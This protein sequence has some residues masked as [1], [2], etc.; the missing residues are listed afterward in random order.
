MKIFVD[1]FENVFFG[2]E[3]V[4]EFEVFG[5][6]VMNIGFFYLFFENFEVRY[7]RGYEKGGDFFIFVVFVWCV[8]YYC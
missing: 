3:Y 2:N 4:G 6:C 7:V 8:C 1:W 5:C